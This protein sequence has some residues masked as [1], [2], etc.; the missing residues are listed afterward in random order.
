MKEKYNIHITSIYEPLYWNNKG[1]FQKEYDEMEL[2]PYE[3]KAETLMGELL[4][5]GGNGIVG[6]GMTD[7]EYDIMIDKVIQIILNRSHKI[8]L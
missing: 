1:L 2:I 4:L 3:G 5:V 8:N 6:A 7:I